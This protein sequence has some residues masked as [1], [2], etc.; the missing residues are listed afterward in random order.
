MCE[1]QKNRRTS[2]WPP[3]SLRAYAHDPDLIVVET[4]DQKNAQIVI[5]ALVRTAK[6]LAVRVK[7]FS[8]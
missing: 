8:G 6:S 7:V 5:A 2:L 4:N 3:Y 1:E